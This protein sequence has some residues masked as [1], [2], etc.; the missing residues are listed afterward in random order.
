M[1][2]N[3]STYTG[4]V[5][6]ILGVILFSAK[7][8]LVK[9]AYEYQIS[10]E[11]LLLFRMIFSLPFYIVIG[12]W[13]RLKHPEKVTQ[14]DYGW[15]LFFGVI[16]YYL[17]SYFDFLGLQYIKAGLERIILFIYPTLVLLISRFF[18]KK[19]ISNRQLIAIGITYVGVTITFWEEVGANSSHLELGAFL[20]FL[21]ALTYASYLVGSG[22]LI[23][24]FGVVT[25]TSYVMIVSSICVLVQY[26]LFDRE[27]LTVYPTEVYLIGGIM[28][29]FSTLAP[30]YL[31]SA[32]IARLGASNFS[33]IAS[34]G[35][36]ST[37]VLAYFLLGEQLSSVQMIG[38][39]IV[40]IGIYIVTRKKRQ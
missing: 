3:S 26:L 2:T 19:K 35:P 31:V 32:A 9:M 8:V 27:D 12:I 10:S 20:I 24:K 22:W 11:H 23:P 1:K 39:G 18:F 13:S 25:F 4:I 6:A 34:L 30:S 36:A 14:S 7:A 28:A 16:G 38:S 5:F 40:I 15:V 29:I 17:A 21:S 37:I 33:I